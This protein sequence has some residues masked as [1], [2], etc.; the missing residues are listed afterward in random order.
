MNKYMPRLRVAIMVNIIAP[1]RVPIYAGLA[2]HFD[3]LLLHGGTENNRDSWRDL[4]KTIPGARVKRAWGWQIRSKKK[5]NGKVFDRRY[6]HIN[7]GFIWHLMRFH[8][9]AV[10]TN[11][12]GVRTILALAYGALWRKSVWVWWGG[13]LHTERKIATARRILRFLVSRWARQWISYGQTSTEYLTSLGIPRKRILQIQNAV[14]EKRFSTGHEA[15]FNL[16]PRPVL[17]H[18]GQLIAR[19]GID[20]FLNASAALQKTGHKFSLL[21]VGDGPDREAL[22]QLA[23]DL[24]LQNV[25]F[26][27][28]RAPEKMPS[29]YRSGDTLILPT[30]ED[31]WGLVANEAILSGLPVLCSKYAGCAQELFLPESVFDPKNPSD[32]VAKLRE[33]IAGRLPKPDSSRIMTSPQILN[34]LIY[35]I[36]A[37]VSRQ[38]GCAGMAN[39]AG[40]KERT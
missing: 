28:S 31:V 36:E 27:P 14:D 32:F 18:V 9:D 1:A 2:K 11:E 10:V 17:L 40:D 35:A 4:E 8:P 15:E 26:H 12:M 39:L 3:L 5:L 6:L 19:K 23:S 20:L 38:V 13:T 34:R 33:A 7:P 30:L 25:H 37:S 16:H 29:V 22:K 24:H 21:F